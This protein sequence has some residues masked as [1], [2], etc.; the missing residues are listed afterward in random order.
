MN[1]L[2]E[3]LPEI[4]PREFELKLTVPVG[5]MVLLVP[6]TT[7]VRVSVAPACSEVDEGDKVSCG[8]GNLTD[9]LVAVEL[10]AA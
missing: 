7:V 3:T 4:G 9:T 8:V 1:V 6:T 10:A 2:Y 5:A